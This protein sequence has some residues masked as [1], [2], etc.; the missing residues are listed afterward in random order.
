MTPIE[1]AQH[2]LQQLIH[3]TT[4]CILTQY[5]ALD[6][7]RVVFRTQIGVPTWS[8]RTFH[9]GVF[10][11][12]IPTAY[13]QDGCNERITLR[14]VSEHPNLPTA[15]ICQEIEFWQV[16]MS[17]RSLFGLLHDLFIFYCTTLFEDIYLPVK[18]LGQG[19]YSTV[20]HVVNKLTGEHLATKVIDRRYTSQGPQHERE[21]EKERER[22]RKEVEVLMSVNHPNVIRFLGRFENEQSLFLVMELAAGGELFYRIKSLKRY[23]EATAREAFRKML[24]AVQYLH[25]MGIVHR[26]LKP[27]NIL[28]TSDADNTDIKISDFGFS[29]FFTQFPLM[30]ACGSPTY[31]APEILTVNERGIPYTPS[32][33]IWS[34]GVILYVLL[35]GFPPFTGDNHIK[36][37]KIKLGVF[38]FPDNDMYPISDNAKALVRRL[39][40]VNPASRI[41][42]EGALDHPWFA[43]AQVPEA[44]PLFPSEYYDNIGL[45]LRE[46]EKTQQSS[47]GPQPVPISFSEFQVRPCDDIQDEAEDLDE[48]QDFDQDELDHEIESQDFDGGLGARTMR[49]VPSVVVDDPLHQ[50]QSMREMHHAMN[51]LTPPSLRD[52]Q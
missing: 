36:L 30:T 12:S 29:K 34:L 42:F 20:Y 22:T 48:D 26:D 5:P 32:C 23:N 7:A 37:E 50:S 19:G 35:C 14:C 52:R 40:V 28:L 41:T 18:R 46:K 43:A 17:V 25:Q 47:L 1:Q 11:W 8:S 33:D 21:R 49:N 45:I 27:E 51:P 24:L 3:P 39:L 16:K 2:E 13:Q 6:P 9:P 15:L 10:E 4:H 44:M 38:S 31:V